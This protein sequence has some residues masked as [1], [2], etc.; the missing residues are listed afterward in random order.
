MKNFRRTIYPIFAMLVVALLSLVSVTYAWFT[1][2]NV[3]SVNDL[4]LDVESSDGLLIS[5]DGETWVSNL[6]GISF[7][8]Q[9]TPVSTVGTIKTTGTGG[10][11]IFSADYEDGLLKNIVEATKCTQSTDKGYYAMNLY[12]QN[13]SNKDMNV[14]LQGTGEESSA[15]TEV[16][17]VNTN[18]HKYTRY[19]SLATRIGFLYRGDVLYTSSASDI[20]DMAT[21]YNTGNQTFTIFEPNATTHTLYA[22]NYLQTTNQKESYYGLKKAKTTGTLDPSVTTGANAEYF[23]AVTTKDTLT[24][25]FFTI[26][27]LSSICVTVY[28][29]IEGQDVDCTNFV[30]GRQVFVDLKFI[31][32]KVD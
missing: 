9:L 2:G 22:N 16:Y 5:L 31:G 12:F 25:T 4:T 3:A 8:G 24:D 26:P 27:A 28:F 32:T 6:T 11:D 13:S 7:N 17:D 29:W 23:G 19:S 1:K 14:S 15:I 21:Q 30:A 20:T 10:I 18:G